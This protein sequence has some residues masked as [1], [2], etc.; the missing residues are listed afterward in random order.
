MNARIPN[1][2]TVAHGE[3]LNFGHTVGHALEAI[4]KYRRFRHGE[5]VGYGMIVAGEISKNLGLLDSI[6]VRIVAGSGARYVAHCQLPADLEPKRDHECSV[7]RQEE[8]WWS[9]S[10]GFA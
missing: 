4:T 8:H 9:R 6:R 10:V 1:A 2:Q 7:T 5:A 3:I